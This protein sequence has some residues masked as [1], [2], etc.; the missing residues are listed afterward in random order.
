MT[1]FLVWIVVVAIVFLVVS[2]VRR[3]PEKSTSWRGRWLRRRSIPGESRA[4]FWRRLGGSLLLGTGVWMVI[5]S[6]A[7]LVVALLLFWFLVFGWRDIVAH[8]LGLFSIGTVLAA[9]GYR[10]LK[11]RWSQ[12]NPPLRGRPLQPAEKKHPAS[13]W[14]D[15]NRK[16]P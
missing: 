16:R 14:P 9:Y 10:L 13:P 4:A 1:H 8:P 2:W 12:P 6:G 15:P 3:E 5:E 7:P 11:D